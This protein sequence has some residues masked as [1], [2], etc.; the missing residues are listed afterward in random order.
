MDIV[1]PFERFFFFIDRDSGE[2]FFFTFRRRFYLQFFSDDE[3]NARYDVRR[4][5]VAFATVSWRE[6]ANIDDASV[7]S[8]RRFVKT[9]I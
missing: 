4:N 9:T 1:R 8:F 7:R 5:H 2:F 3:R 6:N